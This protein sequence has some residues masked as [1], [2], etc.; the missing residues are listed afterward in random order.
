MIRHP[1]IAFLRRPRRAASGR[2]ERAVEGFA[3]SPYLATLYDSP[4]IT[5]F[6]APDAPHLLLP[7]RQGIVVGH[8]FE[9]ETCQAV[10]DSGK[11]GLD[12]PAADFVRNYWGG[13]LA[14]RSHRDAAEILRDPSG[15]VPCYH[16][17]IDD[18]HVVTSSPSLLVDSGLVKVDIDWTIIAQALVFR[19]LRPARTALRGIA[20]IQPGLRAR[21]FPPGLQTECVWSP[22]MFTAGTEEI[23]DSD[24][25]TALVS[26]AVRGCIGAWGGRF[27]N[28]LVEISGGLDSAIVAAGLARIGRPLRAVTFKA[29]VGDPDETPYAAAVADHLGA[30]I[31]TLLPDPGDVDLARSEAADLARPNARSFA[32]ALDCPERAIARALRADAFFSGGG[33][34]NVFCYLRSVAPVIDR[35]RRQGVGRGL[36]TTANDMAILTETSPWEA[37][38]RTVRRLLRRSATPDWVADT[39]LLAAAAT[40]ALPLPAGH[41]WMPVPAGTLP[42]KRAHVLSLIRVQNHLDA[43]ERQDIAPIV[44][45]LLSQPVMEAC[46]RVPSWLWCAGGRNRAIA[47]A[48]FAGDLPESVVARQSKGAFDNLCTQILSRRRDTMREM[49]T[50]GML[51]RQGLL[52]VEAVSALLAESVPDGLSVTRLLMLADVEAWTRCWLERP[53]TQAAAS[54]SP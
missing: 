18:W 22:W 3:H 15:A 32:Q 39:T 1:Y 8:L 20:E 33:G 27:D 54:P 52:D 28:P 30:V 47:R 37:W 43:H 45:P 34:D 16:A 50:G 46:L 11:P 51:A 5:V 35:W 6:G 38:Y 9:R 42:G 13:Y 19:D 21:V 10:D 25:A 53:R 44:F 17:E 7:G 48:A 4:T 26:Q 31:T 29:V 14:L 40:N 24:E 41:P 23:H 49:L 12:Q 2:I 36:F